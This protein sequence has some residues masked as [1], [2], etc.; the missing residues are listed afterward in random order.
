MP[1]KAHRANVLF[2]ERRQACG[3]LVLELTGERGDAL[4]A[5]L[6]FARERPVLSAES[7]HF[8]LKLIGTLTL[9]CEAD[10]SS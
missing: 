4:L 5:R 8:L 6:R 3:P 9:S 10:G 7:Q 2:L 1:K